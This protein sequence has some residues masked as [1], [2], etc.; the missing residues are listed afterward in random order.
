M[1]LESLRQTFRG[2]RVLG[3]KVCSNIK[4]P[5]EENT[6]II[7][8]DNYFQLFAENLDASLRKECTIH[9][10]SGHSASI[11]PTAVFACPL[12]AKNGGGSGGE[13][14]HKPRVS[15]STQHTPRTHRETYEVTR[16]P[17]MRVRS[18]WL[19]S[20]L[21]V[22]TPLR[23]F[24]AIPGVSCPGALRGGDGT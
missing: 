12:G 6:K 11:Q 19:H 18:G 8:G 9:R 10:Q 24:T 3:N 2:Y 4:S 5:Q 7:C 23:L 13:S 21:N 15:T 20:K 14:P 1:K 22:T 17:T 16:L